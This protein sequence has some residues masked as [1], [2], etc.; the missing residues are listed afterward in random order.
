[1]PDLLTMA[2]GLTS[3]YVPLGAVGMRRDDRRPLQG[4]GLLRRP[5]LQQPSAGL[6]G[7][8][9]HDLQVY[10]EDDLI[11]NAQAHGRDHD[12]AARTI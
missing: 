2:K 7:G 11:E 1:M 8:A 3:A 5:H 12:A 6:R 9:R 4:Q 10:E